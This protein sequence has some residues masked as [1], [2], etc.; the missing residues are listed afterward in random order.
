MPAKKNKRRPVPAL[1]S[2]PTRKAP[3][4]VTPMAAQV[5]K[6]LPEGNDWIYELKF[7]GYRA[8][9]IKDEQR[10][11]LRS[12]KNKDLTG[13]Y[14]GIA[15][16]GL[17]LK[18]DQAVVDGEIVAL[19]AQGSPSFQA[20]Q[21]R[22]SHP[23]HQIVFYAFDV[24]HLD[25]TDLTGQPLLKRRALLP[26]V[27]DGSG[28]LASE[29]L[30]GTAAAIV[31]AVLGLGLEGVIA[32][33]KDSLYEPGERSDAWQKLKLENQREF[34]IG[35]YR[36]GSNGVDALLVGYYDETG[37]RFA[38][39]VRA[40][41]VPHL[42]R[43][44]FKALKP[45][46]IDDCPFV[47]LPNP[48]ASRWGGGVTADEMREMQWVKPELVAQIRFVEWTA[49]GRLRHAAFLGLR[50]DKSAREVRREMNEDP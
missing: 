39:K 38:G 17:R 24:L 2:S 43:E 40:G 21:H 19:D 6:S 31:E 44:V 15:A 13:M 1:R 5:V 35:G 27:L 41:F 25:G 4:F 32:K 37:L 33:R 9:I 48:K 10:V 29:E 30:P 12:R 26:R 16:A 7:D 20:L 14:R 18:A 47:D 36:P 50:S 34:V 8:L 23:A 42:R 28:L 46:H 3:A 22:G 11:E 45:H 49:E